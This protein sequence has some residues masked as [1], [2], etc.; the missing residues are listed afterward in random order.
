MTRSVR[1]T[2]TLADGFAQIPVIASEHGD[3]I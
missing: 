3:R 2:S 1:F